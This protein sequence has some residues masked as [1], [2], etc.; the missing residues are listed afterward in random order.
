MQVLQSVYLG[1][2][3][4]SSSRAITGDE[5]RFPDG[6]NCVML[7]HAGSNT[8]ASVF[9]GNLSHFSV[10]LIGKHDATGSVRIRD[11][12][13]RKA[14]GKAGSLWLFFLSPNWWMKLAWRKSRR[15]ESW[16]PSLFFLCSASSWF[17]SE[18]NALSPIIRKNWPFDIA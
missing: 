2:K 11:I 13:F 18:S 4:P 5:C 8:S 1:A 7:S 6:S 14:G 17:F 9:S 3:P 15:H 10:K 12:L 16:F